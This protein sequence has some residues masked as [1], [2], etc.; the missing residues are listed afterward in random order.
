MKNAQELIELLQAGVNPKDV[1]IE[2]Y[3]YCNQQPTDINGLLTL[4]EGSDEDFKTFWHEICLLWIAKCHKYLKNDYFDERNAQ[5]VKIGDNLYDILFDEVQSVCN[6]YDYDGW[7]LFS[8][9]YKYKYEVDAYENPIPFIVIFV[10]SMGRQHRTIHQT[11]SKIIYWYFGRNYDNILSGKIKGSF[12][13]LQT[14]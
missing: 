7:E 12:W 10:E 9:N 13:E 5:S 14:I 6:K 1:A 4:I 8:S 2:F 3:Y 11:F